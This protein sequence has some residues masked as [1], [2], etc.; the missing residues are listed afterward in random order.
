M[1]LDNA[2][3]WQAL[4]I[5]T[6][7]SERVG[8]P[9]P[10]SCYAICLSSLD[11]DTDEDVTHDGAGAC[12][13]QALPAVD[14]SLPL[15]YEG[16]P[17]TLS[18]GEGAWIPVVVP[19]GPVSSA[20][21]AVQCAFPSTDSPVELVSG[22]WG[23]GEDRGI[24]CVVGHDEFDTALESG[25]KVGELHAAAVQTRVCQS[26]GNRDTDAWVVDSEA[27]RCV[28]CSAVLTPGPSPCKQHRGWI[29]RALRLELGTGGEAQSCRLSDAVLSKFW[30]RDLKLEVV[31]SPFAVVCLCV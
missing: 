25:T 6:E 18:Q 23:D 17:I 14:G 7:R 2:H 10:D 8:S 30:C 16:D 26:C 3:S 29:R 13:D 19:S 24:V 5:L 22:L 1:P 27:P 20:G 21:K 9:K 31:G 15:L 12:S 28:S 4:G 11:S